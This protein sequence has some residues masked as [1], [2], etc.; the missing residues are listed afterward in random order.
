MWTSQ[1]WCEI[2]QIYQFRQG[3]DVKKLGPIF[4][5]PCYIAWTR[6]CG[7]SD[8][9]H[10]LDGHPLWVVMLRI[11]SFMGSP[12]QLNALIWSL[13]WTRTQ[14]SFDSFRVHLKWQKK[15]QHDCICFLSRGLGGST[16]NTKKIQ[17][18]G[19]FQHLQRSS[20]GPANFFGN[21]T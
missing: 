11:G 7:I 6:W 20:I 17:F 2:V 12:S 18:M 19:T 4:S 10:H 8:S 5:S 21:D 16:F 9:H 14:L 3:N 1:D 15:L 13:R